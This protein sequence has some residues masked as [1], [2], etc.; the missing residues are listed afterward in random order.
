MKTRELALCAAAAW[1]A[2]GLTA[3]LAQPSDLTVLP[4]VPDNYTPKK[5]PWGDPDFRGIW[6]I[7]NIASLPFQRPERFGNRFWLTEEEFAERQKQAKS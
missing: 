7:D 1:C 5:T 4:A 2:V 3:A 6:P